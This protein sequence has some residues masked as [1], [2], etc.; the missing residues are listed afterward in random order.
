ML[1]VRSLRKSYDAPGGALEVL[2]GIDLTLKPG[3]SLAVMGPSGCGKSTLLQILGVMDAP[4]GGQIL[5]NDEDPHQLDPAAQ[6][7]FRNRFVGFVFQDH[8]LLPQLSVL[9]NVLTPLMAG[10]PASDGEERAR[11]LL[12]R[13]GLSQRLDHLPGHLS[14]GE[15]QR[16]AIARALI[17]Q[18]ALLLADEPTGNLDRANASA[19]AELLRESCRETAAALVVVTHSTEIA[20]HFTRQSFLIDGKLVNG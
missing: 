5:L 18:P 15:K 8:C 11:R 14:G 13:V 1:E 6:A 19:V 4:S 3:E 10:E 17:R 9:E 16:A 7:S 20:A 2:S 12:D